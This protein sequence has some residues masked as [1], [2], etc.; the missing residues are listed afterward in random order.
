MIHINLLPYRA[1]RKKELIVQQSVFAVAPLLLAVIIIGIVHFSFSSKVTAK[2]Q[3][4]ADVQ[5]QIKK[6]KV[7][8]Q[9]IENYKQKK[10]MLLKKMDVIK[11][12][13]KGRQGPVHLLD[14]IAVSLPGNLWLTKLA[15]NEMA[16][17]IT[18]KSLDNISIS[19][20]MV[21]LEQSEY[22]SEV[23]LKEIRSKTSRK[24]AGMQIKEFSITCKITFNSKNDKKGDNA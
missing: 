5:R 17:E 13:Q 19:N 3:E 7:A 12:L 11:D 18:G 4:I 1:E 16:L 24:D 21:K 20:Y 2:E 15:Q 9:E 10:Q 6:S 14:D 23:D 22:F 8:L